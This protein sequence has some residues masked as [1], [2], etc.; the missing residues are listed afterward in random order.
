MVLGAVLPIVAWA[1]L[2]GGVRCGRHSSRELRRQ[3]RGSPFPLGGASGGYR[4]SLRFGFL[5]LS[6][7]CSP[8]P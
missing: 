3:V 8:V 4:D 2:A 1:I 6:K 5:S 7:S